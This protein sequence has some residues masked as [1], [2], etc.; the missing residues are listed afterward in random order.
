ML[1]ERWKDQRLAGVEAAP[2]PSEKAALLLTL[3]QDESVK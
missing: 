1:P 2:L 3:N